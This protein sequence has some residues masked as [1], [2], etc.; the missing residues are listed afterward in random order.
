M[1]ETA[2]FER[3]LARLVAACETGLDLSGILS[4]AGDA[5]GTALAAGS[6][7]SYALSEQREIGLRHIVDRQFLASHRITSSKRRSLPQFCAL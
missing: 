1:P 5:A 6:V 3:D 4:A 7:S 2:G